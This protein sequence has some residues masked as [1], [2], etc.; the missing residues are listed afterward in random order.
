MNQLPMNRLVPLAV[1]V[2]ALISGVVMLNQ[3][4]ANADGVPALALDDA[5]IHLQYGWQAGH[6]HFLQY[7]TGDP[8]STGA[9]SLLYMLLL[10]GGFALGI[11]RDAMPGILLGGGLILFPVGAA[12]LADLT[13]RA[14]EGLY[15]RAP[16]D[17]TP[18]PVFPAWSAGLLAGGIFAGSGWMAWAYLSGMETG[19]LITLI[20]A[21]LWTFLNDHVRVTALLAALA[22]MTRPE[23]VLLAG[24]LVVAQLLRDPAE[25]NDR[26]RRFLWACVPL[27]ALLVGPLINLLVT[28][29]PS[30]TGLLA[31]SWLTVQPVYLDRVTGIVAVTTVQIIGGLLGG[32]ALDGRWHAFPLAQ[33]LAL[34]GLGLVWARGRVL[35]RRLAAVLFLWVLGGALATAT[36][37]T[38][39]WHHYRY[40][41]PLY[42]A[43]LIPLGV[44]LSAL[45][46]ELAAR[47]RQYRIPTGAVALLGI[48]LVAVWGVFS[49]NNFGAVYAL[50][51]GTVVRQQLVLADWLRDNTP[52]DARIA[53][54]DVGLM[55]YAGQ[56][57][58]FDV[59]GL[60]TAGMAPVSRS[61]PG[62][63]YERWNR[64]SRIITPSTRTPPCRFLD[65]ILRLICLAKN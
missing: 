1:A 22:V 16:Y 35:E 5:Y 46:S 47:L 34:I 55:R 28:G 8:P 3:G 10:A 31:K 61:G 13:R 51:T 40:Q 15:R 64:P 32:P 7:N 52:E 57:D 56:R 14:A 62:A 27:A 50:D 36:L 48:A 24:L 26:L 17:N 6:G 45:G 49:V 11:T 29:S 59:V 54:H 58:T 9:T 30:S 65:W 23:A 42:P 53:V 21:A 39:T 19:L 37:Q 4:A 63:I 25:T 20:I 18:L 2:L 33:A 60:T 12:L 41:M 44:A 43:V 38:A